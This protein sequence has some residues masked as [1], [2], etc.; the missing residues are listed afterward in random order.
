MTKGEGDDLIAIVMLCIAMMGDPTKIGA[1]Y[2]F[3]RGYS[4]ISFHYF[5]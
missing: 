4:I 1:E 3:L 5:I 2:S